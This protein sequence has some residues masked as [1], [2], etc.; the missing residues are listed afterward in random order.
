MTMKRILIVFGAFI[1]MASCKE[2]CFTCQNIS[3]YPNSTICE[4]TYKTT[5]TDQSPSWADYQ[6]EAVQAG[7]VKQ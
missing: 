2:Q 5:M 4:D 3:G 7:C 1:F 6:E